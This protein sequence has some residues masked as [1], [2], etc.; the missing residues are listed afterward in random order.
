[1]VW[2]PIASEE[3][4]SEAIAADRALS[5]FVQ[6]SLKKKVVEVLQN[7][8]KKLHISFPYHFTSLQWDHRRVAG[9]PRSKRGTT[10]GVEGQ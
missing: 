2:F 3:K 1:M 9:E 4:N 7:Q 5:L 10:E 8:K 6:K